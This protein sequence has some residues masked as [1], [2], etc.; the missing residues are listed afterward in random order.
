MP[1][2]QQCIWIRS[3]CC[4][5]QMDLVKFI[6]WSGAYAAR[7]KWI[8]LELILT[9]W[10]PKPSK[11]LKQM[12]F[13]GQQESLVQSVSVSTPEAIQAVKQ[14]GVVFSGQ[15]DKSSGQY[16]TNRVWKPLHSCNRCHWRQH[17][18]STRLD[19][20]RSRKQVRDL[21]S[22]DWANEWRRLGPEE[23]SKCSLQGQ[24]CKWEIG[25]YWGYQVWNLVT[26]QELS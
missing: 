21:T 8:L 6:Y 5:N 25:C 16:T 12:V 11:L 17:W 2:S 1:K 22:E 13:G 20:W 7:T 19:Q 14:V 26:I 23:C 18:S 4:L 10:Y 15:Q 9:V 24:A 3:I